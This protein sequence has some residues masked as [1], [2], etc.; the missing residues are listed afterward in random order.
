VRRPPAFLL[1]HVL[2]TMALLLLAVWP[3]L[4]GGRTL[5]LRDAANTHLPAKWAQAEAMRQ[6]RLP[7]IDPLRDGGQPAIGNPN[8][9]PL[10]PDNLLYLAASTLWAFNAHFWLHLLLAPW[11]FFWLARVWGLGRRAAWAAGACYAAS[12]FFLSSLNLYNLVAG[13]ALA[14]AL[15]A[16]ALWLGEGGRRRRRL[17]ALAVLWALLLLAGDPTIAAVALAAALAAVAARGGWRAAVRGGLWLALGLGTLLAAPQLIEFLRILPASFRG[18]WGY[19]PAAASEASWH[20]ALLLGWLV[21]FPFG[22]PDLAYWGRRLT[23]GDLPLLFALYPGTAALALALAAGPPRGGRPGA[24][25]RWAWGVVLAGL[26]LALGGHNPAVRGLMALPGAGLLRLPVKLWL[27]TALGASLLCGFGF[28]RAFCTG[29]R[30]PLALALALVAAAL[31]VLWL[32]LTVAPGAAR[33]VLAAV[34]P[35][36][37]EGFLDLQRLRWAGLCLLGLA[38]TASCGA[39]LHLAVR[40]SRLAGALLVALHVASQLFLL[41]PLLASDEAAVYGRPPELLERLPTGALLLHAGPDALFGPVDVSPAAFPDARLLWYQRHTR[42]QLFPAT[43]RLWGRRYELTLSP[44][45]LDSFLSRAT[46]QTLPGLDDGS[47]L[48]LLAASGVEI[49]LLTRPLAAEAAAAAELMESRTSDQGDLYL[50][51]LTAP[52]EV[53]FAG[54]LYRA[55]HLNGALERILE[56]SFDPLRAVVLPGSGAPSSGAAGR[57]EVVASGPESLEILVDAP[58]R[59]ALVVQRAHLP[60]WRARV[61]GRPVPLLAA[62]IHRL[63]IELQAGEHH[64]RLWVDRRPLWLGGAVAL[65]AM[66]AVLFLAV[67]TRRVTD[68]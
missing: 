37:S 21:P 34:A 41:R 61:D 49:L 57:V 45:G 59:G 53:Y 58:G 43:G 31:A 19:S 29:R 22:G 5:Y 42:R 26:F 14:P 9:V 62:N 17:A 35:S 52:P 46:A 64:V 23:G 47:R 25:G 36:A 60:L 33:A 38:V 39:L 16:A 15:V 12:G 66:L 56:P 13:F 67:P 24:A 30:R 44:E 50:Y 7:L 28:E 48:R 20:P 27:L 51:R 10:Y 4:R 65:A 3:L 32:T 2:P 55:P 54:S 18:H 68:W 6:G 40:R 1:T 11:G 8:T 63:G